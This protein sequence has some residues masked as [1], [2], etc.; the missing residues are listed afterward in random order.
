MCSVFVFVSGL[1]QT[2][3]DREGEKGWARRSR[4]HRPDVVREAVGLSAQEHLL[5]LSQGGVFGEPFP[6]LGVGAAEGVVDV[7][8]GDGEEFLRGC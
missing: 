8:V 2:G 5:D 3:D 6:L 7:G 1:G 4:A